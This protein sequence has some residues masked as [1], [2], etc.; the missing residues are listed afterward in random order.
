[1]KLVKRLV[2]S[3]YK[4]GIRASSKPYPILIEEGKLTSTMSLYSMINGGVGF[5]DGDVQPT[6]SL[7]SA[8]LER[9]LKD[10][11]LEG[12]N[13]TS[14]SFSL[15]SMELVTRLKS[16]NIPNEDLSVNSFSLVD[17]SMTKRLIDSSIGIEDISSTSFNLV[18]MTMVRS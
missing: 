9:R 10:V 14:T 2:F 18:S 13:I 12:D 6:F 5:T 16:G 3:L 8:S 1:M 15:I 11:S 7:V 17:M 4:Q